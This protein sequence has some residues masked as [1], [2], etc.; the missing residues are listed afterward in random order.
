MKQ[1]Y[2]CHDLGE[3]VEYIGNK[4]HMDRKNGL[5]WLTQPV[6]IQSFKDEFGVRENK[7]WDTP[8]LTGQILMKGEESEQLEHEEH[9]SY[10]AGV[11]KA[12]IF[13]KME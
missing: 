5:V 7:N 12:G 10:R 2:E 1:L 8:V 13:I 11:G 3:L 6:L 9:K 4:D